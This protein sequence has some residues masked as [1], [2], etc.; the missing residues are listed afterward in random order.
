M[1]EKERFQLTLILIIV[2]AVVVLLLFFLAFFLIRKRLIR[3]N[4]KKYSYK[5]IYNIALDGDYYLINNLLLPLNE[6]EHMH[7]DHLLFGDKYIYLIS[8]RKYSHPVKGGKDDNSWVYVTNKKI[9]EFVDNPYLMNKKRV[10]KLS[11]ISHF[12]MDLLIGIVLVNDEAYVDNKIDDTQNFVIPYSKLRKF[13]KKMENKPVRLI[14]KEDLAL[15][16]KDIA[17]LNDR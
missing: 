16:V 10:E 12:N 15:A 4:F 11:M 6:E 8:T 1:G 5:L 9:P 7:I 3:N 2:A 17:K 13:I 14:N